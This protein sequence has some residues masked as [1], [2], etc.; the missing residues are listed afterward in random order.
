[1]T[2]FWWSASGRVA[3]NKHV[4][5]PG[6]TAFWARRWVPMSDD[7]LAGYVRSRGKEPEC[8]VCTAWRLLAESADGAGGEA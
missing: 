8:E 2:K 3:C 5:R 6:S 4:P 1:M 7:N